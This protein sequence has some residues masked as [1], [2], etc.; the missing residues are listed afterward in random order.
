MIALTEGICALRR[1]GVR[2]Y[3]EQK[4]ARSTDDPLSLN[5]DGWDDSSSCTNSASNI[6][7]A[8]SQPAP[9]GFLRLAN[10]AHHAL[11]VMKSHIRI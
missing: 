5:N 4:R 2:L 7:T 9:V 10:S 11:Q 8:D 6:A 3:R 1:C